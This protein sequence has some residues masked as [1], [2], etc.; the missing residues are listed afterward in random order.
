MRTL[1]AAVRGLKR[2]DP[3]MWGTLYESHSPCWEPLWQQ[4]QSA[5]N[6]HRQQKNTAYECILV[7][8][9]QRTK[10]L[11]SKKNAVDTVYFSK[12]MATLFCNMCWAADNALGTQ[13]DIGEGNGCCARSQRGPGRGG[14]DEARNSSYAAARWGASPAAR[15][16]HGGNAGLWL[17]IT[18]PCVMYLC[19]VL[20]SLLSR[21]ENQQHCM[22]RLYLQT[23][24]ACKRFFCWLFDCDKS[25]QQS[26]MLLRSGRTL[27]KR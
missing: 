7:P 23:S 18:G 1:E 13:A 27:R 2:K 15:E 20:L 19:F 24:S 25:N 10:K 9:P 26:E 14:R 17:G 6:R 4:T 8:V 3:V 12:H 11:R 16:A 21:S 5:T 22:H